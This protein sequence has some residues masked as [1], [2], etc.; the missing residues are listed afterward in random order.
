MDDK[1]IKE[2]GEEFAQLKAIPEFSKKYQWSQFGQWMI[3]NNFHVSR[4][5]GKLNDHE[6][7]LYAEYRR[8]E[9]MANVRQ[10]IKDQ[11]D[12]E[13]T[14]D[15]N[16]RD[17]L[18]IMAEHSI[19]IELS[20]GGDADGVKLFFDYEYCLDRGV[21]YWA[22]WGVYQEVEMTDDEAREL[23]N[24]YCIEPEEFLRAQIR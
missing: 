6:Q 12:G 14:E 2:Y 9:L 10:V 22:D 20:T 3:D 8:A 5:S 18:A 23:L 13:Y 1:S 21:Y 11:P 7:R 24:F 4:P 16:Y 17:P 19:K 15:D